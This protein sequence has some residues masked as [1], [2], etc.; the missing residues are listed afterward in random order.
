M[1]KI[2][3]AL[4]LVGSLFTT[5]CDMDK[6]PLGALDDQTAIQ[7]L[8]DVF[9]FRNGLYANLRGLTN[10]SYVYVTDM[11][12]DQFQALMSYG[13]R[14]GIIHAGTFTSAE[15]EFEGRWASCY[16]VI[17]STNYLLA[18]I[19]KLKEAGKF[20]GEDLV[21]LNRYEGEAKFV[22][23]YTYYWLADHFCEQYSAEIADAAG[24]GLPLVT[25][26]NPTGDLS[27]YP[28][29]STQKETYAF[30]DK[31]LQ[32]AYNELLAYEKIDSKNIAPDAPNLS[33]YA[34]L[35]LQ[36]RIALNKGENALAIQKAEA[37]I[38]S[39]KYE[40]TAYEDFVKMW[41]ED[42]STEAIFRPFMNIQELSGSI[43]GAFLS[44]KKDD[45]DYIPSYETIT[46]YD[47]ENDIRFKAYFTIWNLVI[48][49]TEVQAYVFN[50]Y[51]GN[52]SLKTGSEPNYQ[53]MTKPFRLG[54]LYLIV[55]EAAAKT[56]ATKANK[57]LNE[58][59]SARIKGYKEV[60]Y[61]GMALVDQIR[62]ERQRELL[63]EGF[64][65]TDLRRWG[66][67]FQRGIQH[68][69]NEAIESVLA[70]NGKGL[71]YQADDYRFVWPIPSAEIQ[72]NPQMK[73]QQNPGY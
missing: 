62:L 50:K 2:F 9:R 18:E 63:G 15:G 64:R 21:S 44:T 71:S 61:T 69:E 1:K 29:R 46:M 30:I 35:A 57:Y 8:N 16:S 51:P 24:K 32:D 68:P 49:S 52:E 27:K 22:R 56:D 25:E 53:N 5:S 36:A 20:Q 34:V 6:S 4:C 58:L 12:A 11:Q 66:L 19:N 47:R 55:A 48:E 39:G 67:G 37:V 40:L 54:E 38:N 28:G 31:D 3:L 10:G 23:A 17:A 7:S 59:R 72:T 14:N 45:A 73:G 13:N 70:V 65:L 60:T 33:S 42:V 41:T 26:Y 43:G